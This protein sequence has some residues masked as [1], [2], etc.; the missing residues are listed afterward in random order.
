MATSRTAPAPD[1]EPLSD[2]VSE[3]GAQRGSAAIERA[4]AEPGINLS[5]ED[6]ATLLATGGDDEVRDLIAAGQVAQALGVAR[7]NAFER[8]HPFLQRDQVARQRGA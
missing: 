6:L 4:L 1:D 5:A 3:A 8:Q 7:F 2:T